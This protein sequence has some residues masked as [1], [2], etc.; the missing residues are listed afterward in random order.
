MTQSD[1]F[2]VMLDETTDCSVIEQLAIHGQYIAHATGELKCH[3][4]KTTIASCVCGYIEQASLD[5]AKLCDI[6]T[7]GAATVIGC[8]TGVVTQLQAIHPSTAGVYCAAH[9]LNL[10]ST[11]AIENVL[12]VKHFKST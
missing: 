12:Y 4:V 11:Q 5:M 6:G 1:H 8:S 2:S 7:D 3:C 10:A 9:R